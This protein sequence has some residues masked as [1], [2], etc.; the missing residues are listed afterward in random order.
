M[1]TKRKRGLFFYDHS[2]EDMK[3]EMMKKLLSMPNVLI[4]PHQAFA[5]NEALD[6]I[7]A[8]TFYNID[9]WNRD[10]RSENELITADSPANAMA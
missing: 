7:A 9:C 8:T 6:N 1:Y 10:Q 2:T 3:D 4:T 5:T